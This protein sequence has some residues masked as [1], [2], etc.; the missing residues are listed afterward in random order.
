MGHILHYCHGCGEWFPR[1]ADFFHRSGT[2]NDGFQHRCKTCACKASREYYQRT[3]KRH[4]ENAS[5]RKQVIQ[6]RAILLKETTPCADCGGKFPAVCMDFDHVRGEK[7]VD[8]SFMV[9]KAYAW[10]AVAA[11]IAKCDLVCA[12]CHR[13]RTAVRFNHKGV[14]SVSTP[15]KTISRTKKDRNVGSTSRRGGPV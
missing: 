3:K 8:V 13:L 4:K 1:T 10:P 15:G 6:D 14:A 9:Q 12:N 2:Q 5:A 11:E 7:R